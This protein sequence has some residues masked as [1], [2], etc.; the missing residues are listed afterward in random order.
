MRPGRACAGRTAVTVSF[1]VNGRAFEWK[2]DDSRRLLT[3]LREACAVTDPKAGCEI[4]RCGAC[5]VLLDGQAVPSCLVLMA[6]VDG[7]QVTTASGLGEDAHKVLT[8]L[9]ANGAIQC[10]YCTAG[11]VTTLVAALRESPRPSAEQ[12]LELLNGHLCRCGGYAGL[13]RAVAELTA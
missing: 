8:T 2:G 5:M 13:R 9:A 4:G 1:E 10:G 7:A 11:I 12:I 6:R 3:V